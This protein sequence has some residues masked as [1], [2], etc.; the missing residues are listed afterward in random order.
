MSLNRLGIRISCGAQLG[1]VPFD[2]PTA[3]VAI[4]LPAT[5]SP[6]EIDTCGSIVDTVI[7]AGE[8]RM[9]IILLYSGS[10]R[11]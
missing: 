3:L 5:G 10:F 11:F 8:E 4:N 6:I 2:V 9:Q 7:A 1:S